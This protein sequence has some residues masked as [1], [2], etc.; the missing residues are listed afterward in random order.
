[1]FDW[2]EVRQK[3]KE[4]KTQ[5]PLCKEIFGANLHHHRSTPV[6]EAE[7]LDFEAR[8]GFPLPADYREFLKQIGWGN[9]NN[10]W[11][12]ASRRGNFGEQRGKG[13]AILRGLY[14]TAG[15]L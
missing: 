5:D 3:L 11:P 12:G 1:M 6:S 7:L 8:L 2:D 10:L 14:G 4:L 9:L 15:S 13:D